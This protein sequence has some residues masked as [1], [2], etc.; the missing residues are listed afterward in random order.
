[1]KKIG[2]IIACLLAAA[3]A[4]KGTVYQLP[5]DEVHAALAKPGT[6][7]MFVMPGKVLQPD[8]AASN[9]KMLV[10]T[11]NDG[12]AE[13]LRVKAQLTPENALAT[14]LSVSLEGGHSTEGAAIA[15]ALDDDPKIRKAYVSAVEEAV[16]AKI[17]NRVARTD[18]FKDVLAKAVQTSSQERTQRLL[19]YDPALAAEAD[20]RN[21]QLASDIR[22]GNLNSRSSH[23]N[24]AYRQYSNSEPT[25]KLDQYR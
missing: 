1:M 18:A 2:I 4:E 11:V 9:D 23:Q 8:A 14:R 17:E 24:E 19:R 7:D 15:E 22:S 12:G 3:C 13:L 10:W 6:M 5:L 21:S 20:R 25:V 16:A